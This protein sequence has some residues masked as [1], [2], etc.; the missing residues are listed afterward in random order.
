M[1]LIDLYKKMYL[2]SFYTPWIR[3]LFLL[4]LEKEKKVD[5]EYLFLEIY[6]C[7]FNHN[8]IFILWLAY[9]PEVI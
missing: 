4:P 6:H 2:G 5:L 1:Y 8:S 7:F 3:L 9:V